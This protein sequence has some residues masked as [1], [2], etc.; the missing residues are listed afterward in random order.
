MRTPLTGDGIRKLRADASEALVVPAVHVLIQ[1][2]EPP[3]HNLFLAGLASVR[4]NGF[5][6]VIP[7]A[8]LVHQAVVDLE[9]EAGTEDGPMFFLERFRC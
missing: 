2:A 8:E 1:G 4:E 9:P 7:V 3:D 5:M 6:L